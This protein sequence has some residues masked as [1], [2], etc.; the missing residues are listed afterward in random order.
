MFKKARKREN[1]FQRI[2]QTEKLSEMKYLGVQVIPVDR[3]KGSVNRWREFDQYF[4]EEDAVQVKL[5]S[6]MEA[7]DRF[8]VLPPIT[9]YKVNDEYYVIDGN[10]RVVAAK[11]TGQLDIDAEVYELLPPGDSLPHLLWR[12]KSKFEFKTGLSFVFTEIGSYDRLMVYLRLYEKQLYQ[13]NGIKV[14]LKEAGER[15]K[16]IIYEP[17]VKLI[18]EENLQE[19]F[20]EHTLDDLVLYIIHHR[21][22]KSRLQGKVINFHEAIA[23]FCSGKEFGL[24]A[25]MAALFKGFIFKKQCTEHCLKCRDRCPEGLICLENGKLQIADTCE[26]CGKCKGACPHNNLESY[27]KYAERTFDTF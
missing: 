9:V 14:N 2:Y 21:V 8:V 11:A 19:T 20:P 12:E 6:V 16:E 18:R 4:R 10:H 1:V 3:I 17:L 15:W 24:Q 23:D 22:V 13:K 27:E 5:R 7:M 25:K 26:G